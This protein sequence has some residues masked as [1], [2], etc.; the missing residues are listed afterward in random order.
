MRE[1][2][3]VQSR[4]GARNWSLQ[5]SLHMPTIWTES[6][7]TPTQMDYLR[8]NHRLT[9]ADK[10]I[11]DRLAALHEGD[12]PPQPALSYKRATGAERSRSQPIARISRL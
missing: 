11:G 12:S 1:R 5:R 3:R 10:E 8:L 4:A 6:C 2:R 7:W 9:V